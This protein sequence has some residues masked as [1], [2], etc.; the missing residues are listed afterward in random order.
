[1]AS[2]AIPADRGRNAQKLSPALAQPLPL[3]DELASV[4]TDLVALEAMTPGLNQSVFFY[5]LETSNYIDLNGSDT[6]AAA[7][8]IKVPI[9]IAF[10]QAVDAGTVQ[11]DQALTLREDMIASGSG[12]MQFDEAGTQYT[13]LEVATEMI[14]NSDN[15]ATNL[16]ITL[17]GGTEALNQQ[18]RDWGLESTVLRNLLPDL[19][20]TNTTSSR[21]L[22][23]AI[24]LV[25]QGELLS[26]RSRDRLFGIMQ[27]TFN[28]TLIPDGLLDESALTYNKTGDIGTS[29]GDVALVDVVNGKR[30]LVSVLVERPFNDGRA[31]ELIRRV[32]GR[33][34]EEMSQPVNPIGGR[35]PDP[36]TAPES[37]QADEA[38]ISPDAV[39][40]LETEPE[41]YIAPDS[42][43]LSDDL[44]VP[45][46]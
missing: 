6:V 27:R 7:S 1:V 22:V 18:F 24:A 14:V 31:S 16:M 45:P 40:P 38:P 2:D 25:D 21:D 17:L 41:T 42:Q 37:P 35:V 10:L 15:T 46:G 13:A 43:P 34:Y 11:L 44:E 5:D 23:R 36:A 4:K 9:L 33:L 28:R 19:D 29:L 12:D 20:G 30:Y 3:A 32:S 8:T 26:L 39:V